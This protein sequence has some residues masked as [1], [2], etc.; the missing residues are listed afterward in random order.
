[1]SITEELTKRVYKC[2]FCYFNL[3]EDFRIKKEMKKI[4]GRAQGA[5]W[6]ILS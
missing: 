6:G 2:L 1:M 4:D 5:F 3:S